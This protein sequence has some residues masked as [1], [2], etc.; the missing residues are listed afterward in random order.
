MESLSNHLYSS[1]VFLK[2]LRV[3]YLAGTE[4]YNRSLIVQRI[5]GIALKANETSLA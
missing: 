2:C 4:L 3:S 5:E 1:H